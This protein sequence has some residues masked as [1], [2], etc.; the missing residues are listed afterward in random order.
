MKLKQ[1]S[2]GR[3]NQE[4]NEDEKTPEQNNCGWGQKKKKKKIGNKKEDNL[5]P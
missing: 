2:Q 4:T 5:S 1:D 3:K